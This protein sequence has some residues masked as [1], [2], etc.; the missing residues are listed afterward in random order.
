MKVKGIRKKDLAS[1]AGLI[2][3]A[4]M[5]TGLFSSKVLNLGEIDTELK[6]TFQ[7]MQDFGKKLEP[8]Q[9]QEDLFLG[10]GVIVLQT[11]GNQIDIL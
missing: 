9:Q 1:K 10:V 2:E 11:Q 8:G 6:S 5:K 4:T 7:E 3:P